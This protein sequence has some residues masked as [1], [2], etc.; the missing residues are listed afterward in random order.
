MH[1]R[2]VKLFLILAFVF[3]S[4]FR[5][6]FSQDLSVD[7][8]ID[9]FDTQVK[10]ILEQNC[11]RCHGAGKE[12]K[13]G[14]RL[15]NRENILEG[16]DS[17]PAV[18]LENPAQSFLLEMIGYRQETAEMP[19]DGRLNDT[20][21]ETLAKWV[22]M[23][24]PY[25][26]TGVEPIPETDVD[27]WAY[28]PV[29]RPKVP[30][31]QNPNWVKNPIDAFILANLEE[32]GLTPVATASKL[33]L[34]RRGYYDL[35]GLPPSPDAVEAFLNDTSP[36]AYE[37]LLDKLLASPRY[38]EKWGRHW[39]D[40]VR[41]AETN[42]YERDSDKPFAWRYR[43]YVID[44][45]NTDKPYNQ[46]IK[47]QLAGDELD[48]VTTETIIATGYQRLG[49][50]DDEP[51][52]RKLARYDYL[53]DI[54][55]TTGQVML[56]MTIGCA[57][58]HDHKIDPISTKDYYSLLA[59]FHDITPHSREPLVDIGTPEQRAEH[60]QEVAEKELAEQKLQDEMFEKQENFKIEFT[61]AEPEIM[62]NY[63]TT[64]YMTDLTYRFYRQTWDKLP[65]SFDELQPDASG[66]IAQGYFSLRPASRPTEIGLVFVAKL[67]VPED[68]AYTF[69]IDSRGGSRLFVN[70]ISIAENV[71]T[72]GGRHTGTIELTKG[73]IPIRLEFFNKDSEIPHLEVQWD[74]PHFENYLLSIMDT[75]IP[76][77][78]HVGQTWDYTF[79]KPAEDW[80]KPDFDDSGWLQGVGGFGTEGTLGAVVRTEWK[81]SDIW[82]RKEFT[83]TT[84]PT[85]MHLDLH[86]DDD[87]W[88]YL[89][90][91]QI[92]RRRG[93]TTNYET[94]RLG[95]E[96]HDGLKT[97]RHVIA[98]HCVQTDGGQYIDLAL[99][100]NRWSKTLQ[101]LV[102]AHE[103]EINT[104]ES[105]K[106]LVEEYDALKKQRDESRRNRIIYEYQ[107]LA[108][109]EQGQTPT[110]I[111]RRGNPHLVGREVQ[112]A[113]PAVLNPPFVKISSM[114]K[115]AK[116]SGKRRVLAEWIADPEN[117]MTVRV[118]VNRIWQYHFGR[119]IVR[120]TNDFGKFGT[121]P[122]HPQLLD[123]L[124]R[125]F[126]ASGWRLK[127]MH[128][129][130]MTSNT[131]QMSSEGVE[132]ALV[133]DANNEH[134]WRFNMR[135][136]TAEEIRDTILWVTGELNFKMWGPSVYPEIPQTVLTTSSMPTSVWGKSPPEEANRR[137]IYVKVKRSLLVPILNQFDQANTDST[138]P[139]RFSTIVPTQSLTMLNGRFIN[140]RAEAFANRMRWEGGVTIEDQVRFG[141][142]L[143]LCREPE[144][145]EVDQGLQFIQELQGDHGVSPD[146]AL[147]RFALLALNLNEFIFLD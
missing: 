124:A 13:G 51:A 140:D 14:L 29:N 44:S 113:F 77:S 99:V 24:I 53:D 10:S 106:E 15:T 38:G 91:K 70:G 130:I 126:I 45:F 61:S 103:K 120:T 11:F 134:F 133:Q 95:E 1:G 89:G 122:T 111:L 7:E 79:E 22:Y 52:D 64:A 46:F 116:S 94:Y 110:H 2:A 119:G 21:I 93:F 141:L 16:G 49:V 139:V 84:L 43:D 114:A 78:R 74:G 97:G 104:H 73:K 59:F 67:T 125:E 86:H 47:E 60:A 101:E 27:Y 107:A 131:Y 54:V 121:Q 98:V 9:F 109:A 118:I 68:G 137:S 40:L 35:T 8:P 142:R 50:W 105:L 138:C 128:K 129:L 58:C 23:G 143:V 56:G 32:N 4:S 100:E 3:L 25:T 20:Q 31:L 88:V 34:I 135:R 76:D 26:T 92:F 66:P 12:I 144:P 96:V 123:W 39:L 136:L 6:V 48:V 146:V 63:H 36:N 82:L 108:I 90:G 62:A 37:K 33:T 112:P 127:T 71:S 18:S 65:D 147:E 132:Q 69:Y 28:L 83:L 5:P 57:R 72:E 55:S 19:P 145:E 81:T 115:D 17:G 30:S 102:K 41:Y 87:V 42:G 75:I 85:A 80:M 117:P